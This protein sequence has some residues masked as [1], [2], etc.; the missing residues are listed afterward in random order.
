MQTR[1]APTPPTPPAAPAPIELPDFVTLQ[2][3]SPFGLTPGMPLSESQRE[4]IMEARSSMSDQLISAQGRRNEIAAE[5]R[6]AQGGADRAG[7]EQRLKQLDQRILQIETDLAETGRIITTAPAAPSLFASGTA[8]PPPLGG[9]SPENV[10][11][12]SVVFILFVMA[13]LA[14]AAA[15]L[16][17][18]RAISPR[19]AAPSLESAHRLERVE[20][21]ID[22][23][24]VEIERI[25]EGQRFVTRILTEGPARTALNAGQREPDP[26]LVQRREG[27]KIP[28][29]ER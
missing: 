22:A 4:A 25:S 15:R 7:L 23:V 2:G 28:R 26:L 16:L 9:L 10:T 24:A 27:A 12:L 19:A 29:D 21:A 18:K 11:M 17:W 3:G 5:L 14:I 6:N 13:P 1:T 8:V 20:Q